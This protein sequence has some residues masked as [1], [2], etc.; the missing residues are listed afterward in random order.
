M[1]ANGVAR[2]YENGVFGDPL[3]SFAR[4]QEFIVGRTLD[5]FVLYLN[6]TDGGAVARRRNPAPASVPVHFFALLYSG[7]DTIL[8]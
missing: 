7:G 1:F 3:G 2:V 5:N 6:K 8:I 4:V